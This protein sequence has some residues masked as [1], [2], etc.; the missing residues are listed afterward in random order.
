MQNMMLN[1]L[2]ADVLQHIVKQIP[3]VNA[4]ISFRST[5]KDTRRTVNLISELQTRFDQHLEK[6]PTERTE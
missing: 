3:D 6:L 2:P 4:L 5:T 1:E